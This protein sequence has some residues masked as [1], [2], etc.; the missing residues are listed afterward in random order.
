M[1]TIGLV[2]CAKYPALYADDLPLVHELDALGIRGVPVVWDA[3]DQPPVDAW[4]VRSAWDYH[5]KADEFLAWVRR[6]GAARPMWNAPA[7]IEWNAHKT[8]LRDLAAKGVATVPTLWVEPGRKVDIAH[9]CEA[10]GWGDIVVKPAVS[11]SA[12]GA[13]RFAPTDRAGAQR[14]AESLAAKGVAMVQPYLKSVEGYGERS[15]FFIDGAHTHAVK[16]QAVLTRGFEMDQPASIVEPTAAESALCAAA[17][18]ALPVA[19]LYA[20]V[21]IAP[22]ATGAPCLMELELIEP[23]LYLREG[24]HAAEKLANA[25]SQR[26]ERE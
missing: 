16:R 22:D 14:H 4:I 24:L 6:T 26:L 17:L 12:H 25:I 2:T 5:L 7:L 20:R 10:R 21:D 18:A 13:R 19:P 23:R 8:Y 9:E 11:A 3:A 1:R 15:F